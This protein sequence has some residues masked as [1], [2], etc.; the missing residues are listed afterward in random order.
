MISR[1]KTHFYKW[2]FRV[3]VTAFFT[4]WFGKQMFCFLK[5]SVACFDKI[6]LIMIDKRRRDDSCDDTQLFV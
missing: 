5:C 1:K 4:F 2:R 6:P 3:A